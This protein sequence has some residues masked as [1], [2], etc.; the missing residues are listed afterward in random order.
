MAAG[1]S[2]VFSG[3]AFHETVISTPVANGKLLHALLGQ[4]IVGGYDLSRDY[5][6]LGNAILVCATETKTEADLDRY[7]QQVQRI[8]AKLNEPPPCARK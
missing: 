1:A 2:R 4:G 5:P 7:A 8:V 3:P 6:E